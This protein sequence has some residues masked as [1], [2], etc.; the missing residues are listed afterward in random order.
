L[1][2]AGGFPP[3]GNGYVSIAVKLADAKYP[4]RAIEW[5]N[6][7]ISGDTVGGLASRWTVDVIQERPDWV[8]IAIGINDV[9]RDSES[10]KE[11]SKALGDFEGN[12]RQLL[13][14]A[15]GTSARIILSEAF[16]VAEEDGAGRGFKVDPYNA[17]IRELAEE[18]GAR[19]VPLD[20]AFRKAKTK[21]PN[22]V[23]TTGDGVH[24]NPAGHTLIALQV[25]GALG[26]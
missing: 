16:Y 8:S 9:A 20:Q 3:F 12:Y 13:N 24:P 5:V 4:E 26:W 2:K 18:Y 25:L 22:H 21:G 14:R 1:R 7:G 11:P 10:R 17:I 15:R 23:W 6:K 19:F